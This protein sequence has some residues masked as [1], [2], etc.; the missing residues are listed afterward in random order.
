ML[1]PRAPEKHRETKVAQAIHEL[2]ERIHKRSLV[3]IF[4]DM[5]DQSQDRDNIFSS[6]QHLKHNKHEVILFH[7]V[8]KSKELDFDFEERPYKF[9]DIETGEQLR[10]HPSALKQ[11][12]TELIHNYKNELKLKCGQYHIDFVEADIHAGF[13]QV[14]LPYLLKRNK[15]F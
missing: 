7:V 1:V 11:R 15:L 13:E 5:F 12:Y 14:L 6:L 3:V 4:S 8:D 2:A 10:L 9:I